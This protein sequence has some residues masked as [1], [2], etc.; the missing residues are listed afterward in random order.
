MNN[1]EVIRGLNVMK[2][3]I[4]IILS[5]LTNETTESDEVS[6]IIADVVSAG[7]KENQETKISGDTYTTAQLKGMRYNEFKKLA[8]TLG[9]KCTGTRDEIMSRIV[10][11]GVVSDSAEQVETSEEPVE[12]ERGNKPA[13]SKLGLVKKKTAEPAK[14]K[15]SI[16]AEEIAKD[17]PVEDIIEALYDV[18]VEADDTNYIEKLAYA[19]REN[20]LEADDEDDDSTEETVEVV[21][22]TPDD[23]SDT[24]GDDENGIDENSYFPEY[25]PE[26]FNN[27]DDMTDERKKSIAENIGRVLN[28]VKDGSLS[29]E[30]VESY[31]ENVATQEE[32][33]LLGEDYDNTEEL[34]LYIELIK[35]NIDNDG[36]YYEPASPDK[37]EEG[38]PYEIGGHNMCCGHELKYVKKSSKYV[39]EHCGTEFEAG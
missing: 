8:S 21:E 24:E 10:D 4:D 23:D 36:K 16:K 12:V 32:I 20:L 39:C 30:E 33:D 29:V 38:E 37:D 11:L 6:K 9:V 14:D 18:N 13:K 3:G 22:E 15:F 19:F 25:D 1:E 35:K 26:G 27:P 34:K 31:I 5:S 28:A 2:S 17:T 7:A